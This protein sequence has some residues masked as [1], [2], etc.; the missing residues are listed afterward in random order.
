MF[1]VFSWIYCTA[2]APIWK[3][4]HWQQL[5]Q[6]SRVASPP[7]STKQVLREHLSNWCPNYARKFCF[8]CCRTDND[9]QARAETMRWA[10]LPVLNPGF[11]T[12]YYTL[13]IRPLDPHS[14]IGVRRFRILNVRLPQPTDYP[15]WQLLQILY[16]WKLEKLFLHGSCC[17]NLDRLRLL[18]HVPSDDVAA[19]AWAAG[20]FP[21]QTF[22]H[23]HNS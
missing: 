10:I 6:D 19:D 13:V 17:K 21:T 18:A 8:H 2:D 23:K 3:T 9:D 5:P 16:A 22:I 15:M 7:T 11:F 14:D 20:E 12:G 4:Q 1:A